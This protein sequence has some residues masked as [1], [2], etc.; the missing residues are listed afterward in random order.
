MPALPAS[1]GHG[2]RRADQHGHGHDQD[3]QGGH[4]HLEGFDLLAEILGRAADHQPGD[5]HGDDGE[6]QH[7]VQP[8]A[9]AAEHHLALVHQPQRDQ[10]A[11]RRVAESCIEL[12]APQEVAVVAAAQIADWAMPLRTSLP[13]MFPPGWSGLAC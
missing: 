6:G 10:S 9:D 11:Q 8:A 5:E 2:H 3:H 4:L 13:S 12:T 7:A 1:R